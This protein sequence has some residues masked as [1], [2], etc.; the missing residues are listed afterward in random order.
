[1]RGPTASERLGWYFR[2]SFNRLSGDS[3]LANGLVRRQA[4]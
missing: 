1:M 3:E 2:D 4:A